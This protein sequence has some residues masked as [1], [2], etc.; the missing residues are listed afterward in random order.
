MVQI[1]QFKLSIVFY[2]G[3]QPVVSG[4]LLITHLCSWLWGK[5]QKQNSVRWTETR[6]YSV[7]IDHGQFRGS[8]SSQEPLMSRF[9]YVIKN[10]EAPDTVGPSLLQVKTCW[11]IVVKDHIRFGVKHLNQLTNRFQQTDRLHVWQLNLHCRLLSSGK[12][13]LWLETPVNLLPRDKRKAEL[14]LPNK[15]HT[16]TCNSFERKSF[17]WIRLFHGYAYR[18]QYKKALIW[19]KIFPTVPYGWGSELFWGC[20]SGTGRL[21]AFNVGVAS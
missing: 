1:I 21:D 11:K 10:F 17:V 9:H 13:F 15:E 12:S 16:L 18:D 8:Y 3:F 4:R 14:R 5:K 20:L 19:K 2:F 6:F 7:I